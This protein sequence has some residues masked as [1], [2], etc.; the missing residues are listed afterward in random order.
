MLKPGNNWTGIVRLSKNNAQQG[1]EAV[2]KAW[3]V[4]VPNRPFEFS[5]LDQRIEIQYQKDEKLSRLFMGFTFI[6]IFVACLGLFGLSVFMIKS[7][8]KEISLRKILGA[9][10][11]NI[12]GLLSIEFLK[13][14]FIGFLIAVP[15]SWYLMNKWLGEFTYKINISYGIFLLSGILISLIATVTICSQIFKAATTNPID[16]LKTE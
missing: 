11:T 6:A 15:V 5:F 10:L 14:V 3:S 4:F 2:E 7:R 8:S 13:L 9:S 12:G 16:S 1:L